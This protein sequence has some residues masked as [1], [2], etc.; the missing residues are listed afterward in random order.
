[1]P[2]PASARS[3]RRARGGHLPG[4]Q[5]RS[6]GV[7]GHG[8]AHDQPIGR[9]DHIQ[10]HRQ[11]QPLDRRHHRPG[12]D[13][14]PCTTTAFLGARYRPIVQRRGKQRALVAVGNSILTIASCLLADPPA[15]PAT[16]PDGY[17]SPSPSSCAR[18]QRHPSPKL[19]P[20]RCHRPPLPHPPHPPI[21]PQIPEPQR[22]QR[23][24][25]TRVTGATHPGHGERCIRVMGAAHPDHG[26]RRGG[27]R[28]AVPP[29]AGC[30]G[31]WSPVRARRDR[32]AHRRAGRA[33]SCRRQ[34]PPRR[35]ARRGTPR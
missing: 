18:S 23:G 27:I 32:P 20:H 2:S 11:R 7:V 25:R 6:P 29:A 15:W 13:R 14:G 31:G 5:R 33:G 35:S 4:S 34:R 21:L 26:G 24:R 16:A 1:M 12:G 3:A 8:R 19:G 22:G 17:A 10:L 28:A 30:P 9:Q